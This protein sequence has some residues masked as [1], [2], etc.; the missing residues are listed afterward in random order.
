MN[1]DDP[2]KTSIG[3]TTAVLKSTEQGS[4]KDSTV[5]VT[6]GLCG[7]GDESHHLPIKGMDV[8]LNPAN[9]VAICVTDNGMKDV[10][11]LNCSN[12]QAATPVLITFLSLMAPKSTTM[13]AHVLIAGCVTYPIAIIANK[14]TTDYIRY[15]LRRSV[16]CY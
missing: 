4:E 10:A 1:L 8:N 6:S 9:H 5:P 2:V 13:A 15:C 3:L 7:E 12:R 14:N 11:C 16:Q